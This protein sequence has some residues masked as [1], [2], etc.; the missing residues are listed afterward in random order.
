MLRELVAKLGS[1]LV[2]TLASVPIGSGKAFEVRDGFY[3]PN[4]DVAHVVHSQPA[5]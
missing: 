1:Y 2:I 5:L 3:I 4:D